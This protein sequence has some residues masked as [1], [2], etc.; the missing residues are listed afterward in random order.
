MRRVANFGASAGCYHLKRALVTP[1][2]SLLRQVW[3]KVDIAA[4]EYATDRIRRPDLN[5]KQFVELIEDLRVVFLQDAALTMPLYPNLSIWKQS[6][7]QS[8]EWQQFSSLVRQQEE[9]IEEPEDIRIRGAMPLVADRLAEIQTGISSQVRHAAGEITNQL[10]NFQQ[11][12]G[13]KFNDVWRAIQQSRQP[14]PMFMVPADAIQP[15]YLSTIFPSVNPTARQSTAQNIT[16]DTPPTMGTASPDHTSPTAHPPNTSPTAQ[17]SNTSL[18]PN[19][20]TGCDPDPIP[21]TMASFAAV[22]REWFVGWDRADQQMMS[23]EAL[24][25]RWPGGEW[26]YDSKL[27]T[28]YQNRKKLVLAIQSLVSERGGQP[29]AVQEILSELDSLTHSPDKVMRLLRT[30]SL[31]DILQG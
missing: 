7:F 6:V 5:G 13:D 28:R 15:S 16:D 10:T 2:E 30:K 31:A 11:Y 12:V 22:W 4:A 27:R 3:P 1:P 23:I 24:E 9:I 20:P 8:A 14:Q 19:C 26:R 25:Q 21:A 29:A 17:P 18:P